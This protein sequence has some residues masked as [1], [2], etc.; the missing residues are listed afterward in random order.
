MKKLVLALLVA[1]GVVATTASVSSAISL[2]A[3]VHYLRSLGDIDT[4]ELDLS[5]DSFGLIGSVMGNAGLIKLEGQVEYIF[6]YLG[7]DE[8]MFIPQGWALLGSMIY[9]GAGI[10][11]GYIDGDWQSDPFYGLRA[12]VNLPLGGL[13]LDVYG[14]YYFWNDDDLEDLTGEDL[15]SITLAAILRFG[16]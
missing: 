6:D 3:G 13:G 12:G 15:D 11:I 8:G 5:K 16:Q 9:G 4:D 14:T 10:G 2:G 7:T 1:T